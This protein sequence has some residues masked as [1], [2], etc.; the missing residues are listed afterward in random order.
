VN[1]LPTFVGVDGGGTRTVA[2]V[3]HG[4][5]MTAL[6]E[7][8]V[9]LGRG[10]AGP[11]HPQVVG[12][13]NAASELVAAI[14]RAMVSAGLYE[15]RDAFDRVTLGVVGGNRPADR[16]RLQALVA[17]RIGIDVERVDL[18][19]DVGLILPAA[20]VSWGVALVSGTGS[21]A[22]GVAPNGRTA[23][24]GGWGY[25][26]GDDGSAFDVG[27]E[28][29]RA[30]L[31]ADGGLGPPTDLTAALEQRLG[32][33]QPRDLIRVVYQTQAPR[34]TIATLAPLVAEV[35]RA[36]D[37]IARQILAHAGQELGKLARAVARRLGLGSETTIV[38]TGGML[39]AGELIFETLRDE[40][41]RAGFLDL[42]R[43]DREPAIGALRLASA[44]ASPVRRR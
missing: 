21:S 17:E 13:E 34:T 18:V 27:R 7:S 6:G 2:V 25:L 11:A 43:L 23:I 40:L 3:G 14:D 35:A 5:A 8:D 16:G 12:F 30:V 41:A 10:E 36:D 20:G 29:L 4:A 22:Y 9:V 38:A 1:R 39:A 28:A 42:R 15:G 19:P 26:I 31:R 37:A 44:V 32:A 24:A 33:S